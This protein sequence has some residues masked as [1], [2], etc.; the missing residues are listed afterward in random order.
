MAHL[1]L[2]GVRVLDLSRLIPGALTTRK[3]SDLG[4]DVV[5]V[6]QPGRGDYL[7]TIPPLVDGEGVMNRVLNRGKRSVAVDLRTP[8]GRATFE[9][10]AAV[11]DVVVE[12]SRPGRLEE[13]GVDFA[14]LRR[15]RPE[16]VVCSVTGFGRTGP[17]A[18]LPSHGMNIDALAG[19]LAV[20]RGGDG[21]RLSS[22]V[23]TSL[24]AELGALNAAL[25]ITAA[26]GWARATGEG[27]WIDASC[28]DAAVEAN[29]LNLAYQRATGEF[30]PP[31]SEFGP[32]YDVYETSDGEVLL[33]C[34]IERKFWEAFCRD[35]GREDL[36]DT[37]EGQDVSFG[38]QILRK[39][40][41][42]IFARD[43]AAEWSRRFL[44][45]GIP[46]SW[47]VDPAHLHEMDHFTARDFIGPSSDGS[48]I[49]EVGDAIRWLEPAGRAGLGAA[50]APGLGANTDA[51]LAEW[52]GREPGAAATA[53]T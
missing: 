30:M 10:L 9:S 51:V 52:L 29:R 31:V 19:C 45:H 21:P 47:V 27:A 11:A 49:P 46:G 23:F 25:A 16:L 32:L 38:P 40:L 33:F 2:S 36:V 14:G 35:V 13:L 24:A 1:P 17:L 20:E 18:S 37:W 42:A 12:V 4:A 48:A 26:V 43:T 6:E 8:E 34:A 15:R 3:L 44:E 28:W 39:E 50:A 7:R 53:T 5:K 41:E 22:A